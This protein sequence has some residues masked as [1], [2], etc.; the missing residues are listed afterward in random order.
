[1]VI[2]LENKERILYFD[3]A[4]YVAMCLVVIGHSY[5]L[6]LGWQSQLRAVIYSFHMPLFF[7]ISGY[8]A[9]RSFSRPFLSFIKQKTIQFIL[10]TISCIL[11]SCILLYVWGNR[12][13]LRD[14]IVGGVWF[15][16]V[17]FVCYLLCFL[18]WK[19]GLKYGGGI[20][21]D[22]IIPHSL[23]RNIKTEF[24]VSILLYRHSL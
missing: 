9:V 20:T 16:K 8:F 12:D 7:F 21:S 13:F 2:S 19:T 3:L 17:L 23:W 14:E 18:V 4:K 11:V 6:T 5:F 10:P 15:L 24:Y 22:S 1:M